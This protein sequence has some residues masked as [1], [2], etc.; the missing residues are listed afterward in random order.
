VSPGRFAL[1]WRCGSCLR[2]SCRALSL[3]FGGGAITTVAAVPI[4]SYLGSIVGWRTV[5]LIAAALAVLALVWQAVALPSL[6][7]RGRT[8]L[9]TMLHLLQHPRLR[10]GLL[11]VLLSFAGHFAFFTYLRPFLEGVTHVGVQELSGILLGSGIASVVGTS[12]AGAVVARKG[13]LTLALMP[14]LMSVLAVALVVFGG[15]PLA[16]TVLVALWGLA[17]SI[18]PVGWSTWVTRAVPEEAESGGG[19]FV[20]TTQLAITLGA[21]AGGIIIDYNG[22]VGVV[23]MSGI[24]LLLAT[25]VS[26]LGLRARAASPAHQA[27]SGRST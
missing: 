4:G 13:R 7:A 15:V 21:A 8:R 22:A 12:I 18:I 11:G 23:V 5:L 6:P 9:A 3:I 27:A 2:R 24:V 16:K 26:A 10:L 17:F 19:L 14:L 20:A 1:Q 25:V